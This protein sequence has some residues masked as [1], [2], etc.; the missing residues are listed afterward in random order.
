MEGQGRGGESIVQKDGVVAF[1][2]RRG[3]E[4]QLAL[5][6]PQLSAKARALFDELAAVPDRLAHVEPP[7]SKAIRRR[8]SS[9]DNL[10]EPSEPFIKAY[11][12]S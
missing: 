4:G 3:G 12:T 11:L 5:R 8:L 10:Q 7:K 6:V 9:P 1:S 2:E